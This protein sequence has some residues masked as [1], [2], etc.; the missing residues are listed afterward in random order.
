MMEVY[1]NAS[2]HER[3]TVQKQYVNVS[4]YQL[5]KMLPVL[6]TTWNIIPYF[7]KVKP[8]GKYN[9]SYA[10]YLYCV[11]CQ[12][13]GSSSNLFYALIIYQNAQLSR[14]QK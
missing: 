8:I 3:Y 10:N 1:P 13:A 4:P 12:D 5:V 11:M 6:V 2:E 14:K 7:L 9:P